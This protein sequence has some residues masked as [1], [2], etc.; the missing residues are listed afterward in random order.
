VSKIRLLIV[1]EHVA[2]R[3]ALEMRLRSSEEIEV[4]AAAHNLTE[5]QARAAAQ[6]PDVVLFGLKSSGSLALEKA[7]EAIQEMAR[8]HIPV[9][10]LASF[11]D[12]MQRER[13]L[14]AGA[15]RYLLKEIN[16]CQLIHEISEIAG[17]A[18]APSAA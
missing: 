4:V 7:I 11:A 2:V 3:T 6:S 1:D 15:C 18:I 14:A 12:D 8:T 17:G 13:L 5:G 9:V 10:V 16:S